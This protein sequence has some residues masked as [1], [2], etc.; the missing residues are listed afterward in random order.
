[1]GFLLEFIVIVI[2]LLNIRLLKD[3]PYTGP[4]HIDV[5]GAILSVLG[6]GGIVLSI[7]AWQQGGESVL[8]LMAV[9]LVAMF[10]FARWLI[11]RKKQGKPALL[12]PQLF[13]SKHFTAV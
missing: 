9:G 10:A 1:V 4:R 12:D 11:S 6:M 2:V 3:V 8:L 7:L 5:V 13:S